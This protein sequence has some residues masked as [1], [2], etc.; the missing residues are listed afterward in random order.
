MNAECTAATAST[1]KVHIPTAEVVSKDLCIKENDSKR[2]FQ[3][4]CSIQ[5]QE[6]LN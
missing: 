5:A 6:N 4:L 3:R 2:I 1:S